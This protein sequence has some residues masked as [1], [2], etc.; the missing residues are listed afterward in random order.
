MIIEGIYGG[1]RSSFDSCIQ[2]LRAESR[3]GLYLMLL[4]MALDPFGSS[5]NVSA[6]K[7]EFLKAEI[8]NIFKS[9]VVIHA[10]E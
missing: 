5:L 8:L 4:H 1:T 10:V 2:T 7:S 9:Y 3:F 6:I